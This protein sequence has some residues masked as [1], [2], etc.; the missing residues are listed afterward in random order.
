MAAIPKK[1]IVVG[2]GVIGLELGSV[3]QRLG[4]EVQV[5]EFLDRIVPGADTE[6]GTMFSKL[7]VKQGKFS[8]NSAC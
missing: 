2:G 6:I 7:L 5:V 8:L 1:L 3:Y 4:S